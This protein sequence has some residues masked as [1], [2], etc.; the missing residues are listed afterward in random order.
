MSDTKE[1][2]NLLQR[3]KPDNRD[4]V[5]RPFNISY[6]REIN[7]R[8]LSGLVEDQGT[9]HSCVGNAITNAFE[10]MTRWHAPLS[11]KELSRLFVYYQSR[12]LEDS[13]NKDDGVYSIR[14]A[15]KACSQYGLC[16]EAL[17]PYDESKV[18]EE[19]S[20]ECY[21]DAVN[22]KI[23]NYRRLNKVSDVI[24]VLNFGK[25]V[26][27]GADVFTDFDMM[28]P[29]NTVI[30]MPDAGASPD[31]SHAMCIV[32]YSIPDF[33]FI[34]KN[35]YGNKWGDSGYCVMPFDYFNKHVYESWCFDIHVSQ[36]LNRTLW[37]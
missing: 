8:G 25:P 2:K 1:I 24:E 6:A 18:N 15:L 33:H 14:N 11:F 19:P 16:T 31:G 22:R 28:D 35:S 37:S 34:V 13:E 21:I 10:L 9:L 7:L 17:W 12:V 23:V 30:K 20:K 3:S 4:Y 26:V 32:G 36:P 29:G 5:Y 27:I